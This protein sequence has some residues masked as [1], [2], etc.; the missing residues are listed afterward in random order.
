MAKDTEVRVTAVW[1]VHSLAVCCLHEQL[2]G[3]EA[4]CTT[5]T[6]GNIP[7]SGLPYL[8]TLLLS[9]WGSL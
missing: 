9:G 4:I 7:Q 2:G 5:P 6:L 8:L 1:S 3:C